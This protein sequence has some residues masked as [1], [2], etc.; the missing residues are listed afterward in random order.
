MQ[1]VNVQGRGIDSID[2]IIGPYVRIPAA[3][4]AR[5]MH[6]ARR[7]DHREGAGNAG[8]WP[9]PWPACN[10]KRRRQVP[11][12]PPDRPDIPC[13]IGFNGLCSRSPRGTGLDS[14]RRPAKRLAG[15]DPS[16]GGSGPRALAVRI[17]TL[18]RSAPTRPS[19]PAAN[20]R[21]DREPPLLQQQDAQTTAGDLPDGASEILQRQGRDGST[22][23][24]PQCKSA[25]RRRSF[26]P[27]GPGVRKPVQRK[28]TD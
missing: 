11:Q 4:H 28:P 8:C 22:R 3:R 14:P 13:T 12:V 20:V 19:H 10:K 5:V 7:P 24:N 15:L 16:V 2:S 18:R 27:S 6:H 25:F 1:G 23:L 9:H 26:R 21:D 17:C